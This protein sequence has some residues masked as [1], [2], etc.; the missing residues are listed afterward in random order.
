[1]VEM[2]STKNSEEK[3]KEKEKEKELQREREREREREERHKEKE[4]GKG[5]LQV[6]ISVTDHKDADREDRDRKEAEKDKDRKE[7]GREKDKEREVA[8]ERGF[9]ERDRERNKDRERELHRRERPDREERDSKRMREDRVAKGSSHAESN[10]IVE[11]MDVERKHL[12]EAEERKEFDKNVKESLKDREREREGDGDKGKEKLK[13]HEKHRDEGVVDGVVHGDKDKDGVVSH[14]V[15]QRKRM[16]RPRGSSQV[17][18]RDVRSRFRPKEADGWNGRSEISALVY[19]VGEGLPELTRLWKDFVSANPDNVASTSTPTIEIRITPRLATTSNRQVR[20]SQLWGTDIYTDDSDLVSVLMHTGY[21]SP[22]GGPPPP[23]ILEIR[24]VTR[25]LPPQD[26]YKSTLRNNIRSRAWGAASGC[27]FSVERCYIIKSGGDS[28]ELEPCINR[29]PAV[30]PTLAPA[31]TERTVTTRAASSNAYRQHRF[32]Q[33]V[34]IQYNLCNE[35]WL[36]YSMSYVADR[37]LKKSQY[38][39]TRLKKGDVLY[40]ETHTSRYELSY[41]GEKVTCNGAVVATTA[42]SAPQPSSIPE[43]MKERWNGLEKGTGTCDKDKAHGYVHHNHTADRTQ[44]HGNNGEKHHPHGGHLQTGDDF[45]RFKWG[46]CKWPLP[47]S[48]MRSKGV[49]LPSEFIEVLDDGLAWEDIQWSPTGVWVKG[50]EYILAR[51]QFLSPHTWE[52]IR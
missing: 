3:D 45:D 32:V 5:D 51:A 1:M 31:T 24:A 43:K 49:P 50:K 20:G 15:Q 35:P 46:R 13:D 4:D 47:L 26:S 39:S 36:K 37:G 52:M 40:V 11:D 33:E 23:S 25:V 14:G 2:E 16:L 19:K 18:S 34:T 8:R 42:T 27:S 48:T 41:D 21:Y 29:I 10:G 30:A 6:H 17:V 44:V 9:A 7:R 22:T 28:I 12:K 38:T